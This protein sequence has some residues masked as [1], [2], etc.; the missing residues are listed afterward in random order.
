[1]S[2][3]ITIGTLDELQREGCL[4]GKAGAQ[5]I[6]VFWCDDEAFALD[7]RCPH[8]GFPLHRGTVES[9]LVTCHWHHARFD[10]T[11]GGTLDPWADDVRAYPVE[12]EDGEV[13]VVIGPDPDRTGYVERRLQDGLEQGTTLVVAKAVLGLLDAGVPPSDI[14]RVGVDFGTRYRDAGWGAG[15]TVLTAM[16]NVLAHL[17]PDDQALALVHGLT[18]VSRDTRGRAPRFALPPLGSS[19]PAARL[20]AW[21]RRFIE[22]RSSD[23]AERTLASAIAGLD[24]GGVAEIVFAAVT[25]HV[26]LD[27]GHTIDFTNKAFEMLDHLGWSAAPDVLPT[28]V[29]QTASASRSEER[30][31][32]RYPHD[33]AAMVAAATAE[34]PERLRAGAER[35]GF[36]HDGGVAKLAWSILS[37]DPT[38]VVTAIDDAIGAGAN[39]EELGRAVAYAAA[40]RITRFHTQNDHG[41]WDQVHHAFTAANAL[42]QALRRAPSPELLRGVYQT[43]LRIHL[44]RFLN[45]PAARLPGLGSAGDVADLAD[46]QVCW[47]RE[48]GVDEA[49]TIVHHFLAGG[50]DPAQVIAALGHALLTEDAEFHWLQTYEAAVRSFHTWPS[51]SEEGALILAGT[52]R[53]LAAHTPTR[54]ELSQVVRIAT[55]LGR[56]E[57]LF[58]ES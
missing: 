10:L 45:V 31:S 55:R 24:A 9:G 48:G 49:G 21:Y 41:D 15:L 51:G 42:H 17:A 47:D 14:V 16:A 32:W 37:D 44:D 22:T 18:F 19:L 3:R 56:G 39:A 25:D 13:R 11:S 6:C 57:A 27:G 4:S 34:L 53:F 54:R 33:L 23:A 26:F 2:D 35:D 43:A 46:L 50:G 28:L 30:G 29:A 36:D 40:L 8:M 20:D 1:M 7:D 12:I 52:A 5:P 58:E 38:E